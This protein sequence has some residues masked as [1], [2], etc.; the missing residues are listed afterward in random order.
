MTIRQLDN[1]WWALRLTFGLV[2]FLA[3]IDKFLNILTD[4]DR[5]LAPFVA[6]LLPTSG[7]W[8]MRAVGVIEMAV[9]VLILTRWTRLGAYI[10]SVWLLGIALNLALAGPFLDIAVRDVA[11]SVGAW[12]LAKLSEIR[13]SMHES[14]R[15]DVSAVPVGA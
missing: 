8:F 9:G 10:A 6:A 2:A 7:F 15:Q 4:W 3:G 5:Y 11:M 12:T 13:Q 14:A 1:T